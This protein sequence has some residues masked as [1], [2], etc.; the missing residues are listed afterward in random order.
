MP[1]EKPSASQAE[2]LRV[3]ATVR[4]MREMRGLTV[5]QLAAA[6]DRSRPYLAN[7]EAGRK[8]LTPVMA[9]RVAAA[10]HVPQLSLIA[11]DEHPVRAL[12]EAA[13]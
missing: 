7:I 2:R 4:Q 3:G 6:V 13:S 11:P 8:R 9:A 10:L 5:D 12:T 1:T